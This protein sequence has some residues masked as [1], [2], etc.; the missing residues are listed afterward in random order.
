M[1]EPYQKKSNWKRQRILKNQDIPG[2][3]ET[4]NK[5]HS[6]D[7]LQEKVLFALTYLTAGRITE[8]VQL[9]NLRKHIYQR[10]EYITRDN[11]HKTRVKRNN[12][13]SPL[14][15]STEK[16]SLNYPGLL[17]KDL[18]F[19]NVQGLDVLIVSMDNR[20]NKQYTKKRVPIPVAHEYELVRL[21]K[22]YLT[23]LN[24][25][26]PLFPFNQGR[27]GKILNKLDLNPHFLRDMRLTHLITKYEYNAFQL[28]R[29]AGWKNIS[30]AE[31]YI[32]LGMRDLVQPFK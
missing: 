23:T 2:H 8:L 14:V 21:I 10:E 31:R 12:M 3:Q 32:R 25:D 28:V 26:D 13:G 6:L 20:K 1:E 17:K 9:K 16:I 19:E 7:S 18:T 30:P 29:F 22:A 4:I 27:A 15:Q 24:D 5:V 11:T